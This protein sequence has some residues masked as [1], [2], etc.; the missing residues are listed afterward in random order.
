MGVADKKDQEDDLSIVFKTHCTTKPPPK[1]SCSLVAPVQIINKTVT[2]HSLPKFKFGDT[3]FNDD[4][5]KTDKSFNPDTSNKTVIPEPKFVDIEDN[6]II[7]VGPPQKISTDK[8][9]SSSYSPD[10]FNPNHQYFIPNNYP[11]KTHPNLGNNIKSPEYN[12]NKLNDMVEYPYM[13]VHQHAPP[14]ANLPNCNSN[15]SSLKSFNSTMSSKEIGNN[16]K[17]QDLFLNHSSTLGYSPQPNHVKS[18]IYLVPN[19]MMVSERV[20]VA[21]HKTAAH[22][23]TP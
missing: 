20:S 13:N 1:V 9:N 21:F 17:S 2:P 19:M 14:P 7:K 18:T 22:C 4:L 10:M 6:S 12:L 3:N 23:R 8:S 16:V 11:M 15:L 5:K